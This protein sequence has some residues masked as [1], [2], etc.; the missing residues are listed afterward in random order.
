[1]KWFLTM[2]SLLVVAFST[3]QAQNFPNLDKSPLDIAYFPERA[4]FRSFEKTEEAKKANMPVIRV[5]YSRPQ[6]KGRAVFG[7]ELVPFGKVWRVGANESAEI[8]FFE[9]VVLGDTK[10]G[11]GRYTFYVTA[12]ENEW[13]VMINTDLDGWGSYA[14][15]P[16]HTIATIKV[17]TAKTE[18]SVEAF[19][20]K[21]EAVDDG[22]HMIMAWDDTMVRVPFT[23]WSL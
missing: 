14:Y 21:F 23:T 16:D 22:A 5:I 20:I 1:M 4:S 18:A 9:D 11:A 13:E 8:M 19:T 6:M 10:I 7:A 17:P 15:N 2:A 12:Q 3:V